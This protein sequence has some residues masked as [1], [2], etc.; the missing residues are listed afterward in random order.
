MS[1][2]RSYC[3]AHW[4]SASF[5]LI[6]P[7][8]SPPSPLPNTSTHLYCY[9]LE[10]M[11]SLIISAQAIPTSGHHEIAQSKDSVSW[12]SW[13]HPDSSC[14]NGAPYASPYRYFEFIPF[15]LYVYISLQFL[16][17]E[18]SFTLS[19]LI[20]S[21]FVLTCFIVIT[22]EITH[23]FVELLLFLYIQFPSD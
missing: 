23:Y 13:K 4:F 18:S 12:L 9:P 17:L 3:F 1:V 22:V 20:D 6:L 5:T 11:D 16:F 2:S 21:L 10:S 7:F 8:Y 14:E 15:F 19:S